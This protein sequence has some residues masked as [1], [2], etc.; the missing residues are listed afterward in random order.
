M[1]LKDHLEI[2]KGMGSSMIQYN[3]LIEDDF[4]RQKDIIKKSRMRKRSAFDLLS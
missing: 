4:E 2:G 1:S 3:S